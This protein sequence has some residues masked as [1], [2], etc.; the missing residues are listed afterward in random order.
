MKKRYNL[1]D[2]EMVS[3]VN[4]A[5]G[6]YMNSSNIS[7]ENLMLDKFAL[8]KI[9]QAGLPY[10]FF[11]KLKAVLPLS[12]QE[13]SNYLDISLK[14]LQRYHNEKRRFKPIHS[15]K[16]IEL[17]EVM[18]FG[19]EVFDD[20]IRFKLWLDTPSF[21]LGSMRPIDLLK[22]SYG[23]DLVMTELTALEHGIFA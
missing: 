3:V 16:I 11:N 12:T 21:A 22:D 9:I 6:S 15:E 1:I 20:M 14:S 23:K 4:E 17:A 18:N 13:W 19:V 7:F 8:V 2:E 5:T 10:S